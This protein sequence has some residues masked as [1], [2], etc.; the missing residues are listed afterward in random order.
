MSRPL[1]IQYEDAF[2]HVIS[3]GNRDEY[4]FGDDGDKDYL[5]ELIGRGTERY[6]VVIYAYCVL[7]NH[8]HL[9]LQVNR[10]NLSEFMHFL[11][12]SYASHYSRS[13]NRGHV[14]AGRYKSI[15][16][17]KEEYLMTL[18]RYIHLNPIEAGLV[19]RPEDYRW[20]SFRYYVNGKGRPS[21]LETGWILEYFG[22]G[23]EDARAR[24]AEFVKEKGDGEGGNDYPYQDVVAQ[25]ILGGKEFVENIVLKAACGLES[26]EIVERKALLKR[27]TLEQVQEAICKVRGIENLGDT[28]W[29][30]NEKLRMDRKVY[31][32]LAKAHT[33]ATNREIGELLGGVSHYAISKEYKRICARLEGDEEFRALFIKSLRKA[34]KYILGAQSRFEP[35]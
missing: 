6:K 26:K 19:R 28:A 1:R 20:S 2:F 27:V 16:V 13:K 34:E 14:F 21:W 29:G 3:K 30:R 23:A 24:Y 5:V 9:L 17:E 12:S 25:A 35:V 4:I 18:S 22:P 32:Y 15:C 11:G 10:P 33:A 7:G 31:I 8:Y